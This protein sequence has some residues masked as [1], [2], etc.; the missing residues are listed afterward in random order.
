MADFDHHCRYLNFCVGKNNY[1]EFVWLVAVLFFDFFSKSFCIWL[2]LCY[3]GA[4]RWNSGPFRGFD[5]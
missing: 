3:G 5:V 1:K 2:I 4:R